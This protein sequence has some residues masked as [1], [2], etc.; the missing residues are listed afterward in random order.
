MSSTFLRSV[1][2]AAGAVASVG[3]AA[4]AFVNGLAIPGNTLDVS[5]GATANNGRVGF[6]SD[7]FYDKRTSQWWGDSDRGPGGGFL[8]T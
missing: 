1:V 4:P 3:Q 2:V 7:I 5:G 6:F 8:N